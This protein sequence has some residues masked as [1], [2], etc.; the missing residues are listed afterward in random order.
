[1]LV[2]IIWVVLTGAWNNVA[3]NITNAAPVWAAKPLT[4]VNFAIPLPIVLIIFLPPIEVPRAIDKAQRKITHTGT[5]KLLINPP[6]NSAI[7]IIPIDFWASFPPWLSAINAPA[8]TCNFKN[9]LFTTDLLCDFKIQFSININIY[10]TINP[11]NGE[12]IN[13]KITLWKRLYQL[14]TSKVIVYAIP[15]PI[16]APINAWD[17]LLGIPKYHVN[18]FQ[19]I[20]EINTHIITHCGIDVWLTILSPT[21]LATAVPMKAPIKLHIQHI[22]IACLGVNAFVVIDVATAVAVSWNPFIKSNANARNTINIVIINELCIFNYNS[23]YYI[24]Y[25]FT[26]IYYIF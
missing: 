5:S 12:R 11:I 21:V 10:P 26:F 24:C 13:H 19:I 25:L 2:V 15:P 8:N 9:S 7:V 20:D 3:H 1:M 18:R 6:L 16:S 14:T 23:F 22:I 17:E 4:G